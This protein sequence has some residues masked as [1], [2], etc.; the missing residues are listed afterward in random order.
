MFR[1]LICDKATA[2]TAA[3]SIT[4]ALYARATGKAR[5]Q[6]IEL[7]MID[8]AIAFMWPD[9]AMDA[10]LLDDD[11]LRLPTIAANYSVTR[12]ADGFAAAAAAKAAA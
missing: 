8:T 6:H 1:T 9:S 5:G 12:L 4:A 10:A 11:V 3:Q 2:Y 7:A